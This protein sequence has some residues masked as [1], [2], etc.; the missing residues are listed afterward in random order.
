MKKIF[1]ILAI[2]F[3]FLYTNPLKACCYAGSELTYTC[4]GG[5]NYLISLS[6][7]RDCSGISAPSSVVVNLKC[8]QD[9]TLNFIKVLYSIPGTGQEITLN[10]NAMPTRCSG[11]IGYGLQE[12]VYQSNVIIPNCKDWTISYSGYYRVPVSTVSN[13]SSNPSYISAYLNNVDAPGNSSPYFSNK[14]PITVQTYNNFSFNHGAIDLDGD[15]LSYSFYAPFINDSNSINYISGYSDTNFL[16]SS[17][18]INLNK[19][20][21]R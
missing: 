10:C 19:Q 17:T 8:N 12:Y 9:S 16:I 14:P 5:N 6:F 21:G 15:S 11:G 7:Y 1:I 18:P 2:G 4:L 13:N 20:Q 3:N